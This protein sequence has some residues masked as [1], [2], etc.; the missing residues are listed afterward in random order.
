MMERALGWR[1][2]AEAHQRFRF[3]LRVLDLDLENHI[4]SRLKSDR[5][6]Q[7]EHFLSLANRVR[8]SY[9]LLS[10]YVV[11]CDKILCLYVLSYPL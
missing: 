5:L 9:W 1:R 2:V 8:Q 4:E 11:T 3:R 7:Q 6:S 10:I